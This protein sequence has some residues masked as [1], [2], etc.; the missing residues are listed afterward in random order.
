MP[1]MTANIRC[2]GE[3]E[4]V[5]SLSKSAAPAAQPLPCG[6]RRVWEGNL[7]EGRKCLGK[8]RKRSKYPFPLLTLQINVTLKS[9]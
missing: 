6:R 2:S 8:I 9:L 7:W 5:L 4:N 1:S 3:K